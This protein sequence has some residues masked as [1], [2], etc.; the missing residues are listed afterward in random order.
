M[1]KSTGKSFKI[2]QAFTELGPWVWCLFATVYIHCTAQNTT[3]CTFNH[4]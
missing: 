2:G 4:T 1:V 3:R